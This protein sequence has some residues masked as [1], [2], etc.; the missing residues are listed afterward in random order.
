MT[1]KAFEVLRRVG[2]S[3][4]CS[5]VNGRSGSRAEEA[6]EGMCVAGV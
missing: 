5:V 3:L 4:F 1:G 2:C 6:I